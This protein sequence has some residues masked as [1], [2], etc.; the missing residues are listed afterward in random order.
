ML[1]LFVRIFKYN[2][3]IKFNYIKLNLNLIKLKKFKFNK[4]EITLILTL[5]FITE[6]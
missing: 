3:L 6:N 4:I 1:Y 5:C 2:F